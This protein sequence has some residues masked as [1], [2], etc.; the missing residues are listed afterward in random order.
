MHRIGQAEF[1]G[2][3]RVGRDE[4]RDGGGDDGRA[5]VQRG[6]DAQRAGGARALRHLRQGGGGLGQCGR[7][8][9]MQRGAGLGRRQAAGGAGDEGGA[10]FLF[11]PRH[12]L[13]D[14]RFG[15]AEP[16]GRGGEGPRFQRRR[17]EGQAVEG[18]QHRGIVH[19]D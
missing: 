14:E 12:L 18:G 7:A 3:G 5:V 9:G 2:A 11:Q 13:G 4:A 16:R 8:A 17:E 19:L 10:E 1:D 15:D 6:R